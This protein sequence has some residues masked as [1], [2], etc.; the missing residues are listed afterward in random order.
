MTTA[1][2]REAVEATGPR[3]V[4]AVLCL[5]QLTG[6]G[7]LFYA[8]P[9]LA[10]D[11][12]ADTGWSS[13]A[14]TGAFSVSQLVGAVVGVPVG[15]VLD[16]RGPRPVMVVGSLVAVVALPLVASAG[17]LPW[18]FAAWVLVGVATAGVLYQPAFAAVTRWHGERR[19]SALTLLTVFGG[20]AGT[21]FAPAAAFLVEH[22]GWRETYLVLA[23]VFAVVTVPAH[24][25]GLR[26][27]WVDVPSG[28]D[29]GEHPA[30]VARSRPFVVLVVVMG[31][32]ALA[33][34]AVIVT[35]VPLFAERGLSPGVAAWAVGLGSIGQALGR[36]AYGWL[37][38]RTTVRARTVAVL[39][40]GSATILVL[41][42][43]PGPPAALVLVAVVA[44][45]VR[46]VF[47]IV[48]AMAVTDRWGTR[49]YG[50]LTGLLQ[51]PVMVVVALAPWVATAVAERIG[52]Y[53]TVFVLLAAVALAAGLLALASTP[54][55]PRAPE[56][57]AAG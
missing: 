30:A 57:V 2:Q 54:V 24:G 14:V 38:A 47:F 35:I 28:G 53:S 4:L 46:G 36:L 23:L 27:P 40:T 39:L 48:Q 42:V 43:L 11:I 29:A 34:Y 52:G 56:P 41:A 33:L 9:V 18:F 49:H 25:L 8:F 22:L 21:V 5:S 44:G 6:W 19:V 16:R 32:G 37:A 15:R 45:A 12:T 26:L 17:S 51:A 13:T 50:R 7:V 20:L 31:L 3:R 10:A 55:R 1:V